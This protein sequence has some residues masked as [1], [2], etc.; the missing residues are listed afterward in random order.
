ME[1]CE[2]KQGEYV[3]KL[4]TAR[5]RLLCSHGFY[6]VML[7]HMNF[8]LKDT[9]ETAQTDGQKTYFSPQFLDRLNDAELEFVLLHELLH[10]ALQHCSRYGTK[11]KVL[12][13]L[14]CDIVVNS[15]IL[16]ENDM[17]E[18]SITICDYGVSIHKAPNDEEGYLYT[19]EEVYQMLLDDPNFASPQQ[20]WDNHETWGLFPLDSPIVTAWK[21]YFQNACIF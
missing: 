21:Q 16:Y 4:I 17:D 1:P 11:N 3:E 10:V 6:G 8:A 20:R 14:A 2:K 18:S 5:T 13:N 7:M 12:F 9:I 19:A 15:H